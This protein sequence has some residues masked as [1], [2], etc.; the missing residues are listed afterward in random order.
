MNFLLKFSFLSL[1]IVSL[2]GQSFANSSCSKVFREN[3]K[4]NL[5]RKLNLDVETVLP[6]PIAEYI[7]PGLVVLSGFFLNPYLIEMHRAIISHLPEGVRALMLLPKPEKSD[8]NG[9][10]AITEIYEQ[11]FKDLIQANKVEFV[12]VPLKKNYDVNQH[13]N[14]TRD[15]LSQFA[16]DKQGQILLMNF[17]YGRPDADNTDAFVQKYLVE[18]IERASGKKIKTLNVPFYFEWGNISTD[19][20]GNVFVSERVL[21][22]NAADNISEKK[23]SDW[24]RGVFGEHTELH[25]VKDVA[26]ESTGHVDMYMKF[27]DAKNVLVAK[28]PEEF[29]E[30]NQALDLLAKQLEGLGKTVQRIEMALDSKEIDL[31]ENSSKK[32]REETLKRIPF[33]SYTNSVAT[34]DIAEIPHY[35]SESDNLKKFDANALKIYQKF[36]LKAYQIGS[37]SSIVDGGSIHCLSSVIPNFEKII[38]KLFKKP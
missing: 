18:K 10:R 27:L 36:G 6:G 24:F 21:Q 34:K 8:P 23:V 25:F 7:D 38:S 28:A 19:G 15:F 11:D 37:Q 16:V 33:R 32:D 35:D 9:D 4:L 1:V 30:W 22:N 3:G 5:N 13:G 29:K 20:E 12:L 17:K 26:T 31:L 14:W 2:S